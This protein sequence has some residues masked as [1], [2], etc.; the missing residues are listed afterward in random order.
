MM[1]VMKKK[2]FP[3]IP[4]SYHQ[5]SKQKKC[6]FIGGTIG[7]LDFGDGSHSFCTLHRLSFPL[8]LKH[9]FCFFA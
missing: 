3:N 6:H 2:Q 7:D 5:V 4:T 8:E 1:L 9:G